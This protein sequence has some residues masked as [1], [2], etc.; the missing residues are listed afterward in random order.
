MIVNH[1]FLNIEFWCRKSPGFVLVSK[2]ISFR[3]APQ[4]GDFEERKGLLS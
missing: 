2:I 4:S 1:H 3:L